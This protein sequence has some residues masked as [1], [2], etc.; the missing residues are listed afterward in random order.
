MR[1]SKFH[2]L[3][4]YLSKKGFGAFGL[5]IIFLILFNSC[6]EDV[7]S[8]ISADQPKETISFADFKS[9]TGLRHFQNK[10]RIPHRK[11]SA[12]SK[13]NDGA[14]E[15]ED[16]DIDTSFIREVVRDDKTTYSFW[17]TPRVIERKTFFNLAV[18]KEGND[19]NMSII[20]FMPS[21]DF[22]AKYEAGIPTKFEGGI[23]HVYSTSTSRVSIWI[24]NYHCTGTG[25]CADGVCDM[26][27][28]CVSTDVIHLGDPGPNYSIVQII[29]PV[30]TGN[31]D[32]G[33]GGNT[34]SDPFNYPFGE[35][36]PDP[37]S[38][39]YMRW[40]RASDFWN[41]L[42]LSEKEWVNQTERNTNSYLGILE[43]FLMSPSTQNKQIAKNLIQS[44]ANGKAVGFMPTFK[45]PINSNYESLYPQFTDLLKSECMWLRDNKPQLINFIIDLTGLSQTQ[46]KN[47]LTW[48]NGPTIVIT[49][50]G[51]A[52]DGTEAKGKFDI[53]QPDKIFIDIDLVQY[54]EN[55][56]TEA[57]F[58]QES[59]KIATLVLYAVILHELVHYSD[60]TFDQIMQDA[61]EFE[62]GLYFEAQYVGGYYE[63]DTTNHVVVIKP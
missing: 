24:T 44:G 16:F 32:Q 47:N 55:Y 1:I 42:S 45:Y 43:E 14:Y 40:K 2:R 57:D 15:F 7:I 26:C 27:N 62:L 52:N 29:A 31:E 53:S 4:G 10:I 13:T 35:N 39:E 33:G 6:S 58:P 28:L 59:G 12:L 34:I 5:S 8:P 37:A 56:T 21:D 17:V 9:I 18:Y 3:E 60:W 36:F 38:K 20:E 46:V 11:S 22:L 19:W 63:F 30:N 25:P 41:G 61:P 23:G 51:I 54:L 48:G 50:L 49:Q